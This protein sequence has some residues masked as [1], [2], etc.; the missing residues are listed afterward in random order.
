MI[1]RRRRALADVRGSGVLYRDQAAA[2]AGT[3]VGCH[4][5]TALMMLYKAA[6]YLQARLRLAIWA[7]GGELEI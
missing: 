5:G 3:R 6:S 7:I 4:G 1:K 2:R